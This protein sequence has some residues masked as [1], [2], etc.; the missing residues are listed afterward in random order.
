MGYSNAQIT[1]QTGIPPRTVINLVDKAIQRGYDP[2]ISKTV[3]LRCV[4]DAEKSGRPSI[5][6]ETKEKVIKE[7]SLDRYAREKTCGHIQEVIRLDGDNSYREGAED[8]ARTRNRASDD[9]VR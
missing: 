3:F 4:E 9:V 8:Q 2:D 7:V 6:Q 1:E 5:N